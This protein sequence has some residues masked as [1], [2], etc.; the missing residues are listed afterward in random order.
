MIVKGMQITPA[1]NYSFKQSDSVVIYSQVYEP[2]LKSDAPPR[3]VAGYSIIGVRSSSSVAST[4][5]GNLVDR[6]NRFGKNDAAQSEF[7]PS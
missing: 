5:E 7:I 6:L 2:L 4:S 1:A 3:V